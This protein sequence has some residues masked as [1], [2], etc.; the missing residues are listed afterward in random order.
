MKV[1]W[2][3]VMAVALS[4]ASV[5]IYV[6]VYERYSGSHSGSGEVAASAP[7]VAVHHVVAPGAR[8]VVMT[9]NEDDALNALIVHRAKCVHGVVY[10]TADHVIEPW[11]GRV[12][13]VSDTD[14]KWSGVVP[15]GAN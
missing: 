11:P 14:N 12:R 13:C 7:A 6:K 9:R 2:Q 3:Y 8:N 15:A 10:K 1:A 4:L 5:P